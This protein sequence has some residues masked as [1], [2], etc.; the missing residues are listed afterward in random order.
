MNAFIWNDATKH[1]FHALKI[2]VYVLAVADSNKTCS[3][4]GIEKQKTD[5]KMCA[6]FRTNK[7]RPDQK[8]YGMFVM[9]KQVMTAYTRRIKF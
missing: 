4:F 9:E 6:I 5:G 7:Q 1:V 3:I 2:S 8:F